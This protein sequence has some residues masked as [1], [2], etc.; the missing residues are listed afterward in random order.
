MKISFISTLDDYW[1]GSEPLWV[2]AAKVMA[3][4]GHDVQVVIYEKDKLHPLLEELRKLATSFV[5][6]KSWRV[7][8]NDSLIS[9]LYYY[10]KKK[11]NPDF[12]IKE[13]L[14]FKGDVYVLNQPGNYVGC[15][16]PDI[17][18]LLLNIKNKYILIPHGDFEHVIL[19]DEER[20]LAKVAYKNA[21][22]VCFVSQRNA[23]NV[24]HQLAMRLAPFKILDYPLNLKTKTYMNFPPIDDGFHLASVARFDA[25][26]KGQDLLFSV[27][28]QQKWK[29][30]PIR[31][32]LYGTGKDESFL[33]ELVTYYG[34]EN[35]VFFH[36]HVANV[37]NIWKENHLLV[38]PSFAEGKPL[39]LAEAMFCGRPAIVTD[40]AGN[41]ELI[42]HQ[43]NGY[44]ISSPTTNLIDEAL[45]LAW[46]ERDKWEDY[47]K[48]AH[49]FVSD[50]YDLNPIETLI[51]II[52]KCQKK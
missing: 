47:G 50:N 32:N 52:I 1:G 40:V 29:L 6:M 16:T 31:I 10:L 41:S 20:N 9:R 24:Q 26:C 17:H 8:N 4:E 22:K 3:K 46:N 25:Q 35:K 51:S 38:M 19:R 44:L 13:I 36:G 2:H 34:L 27:L 14:K 21:Q 12:N 37:Q 11:A 48:K 30:R 39:A 43:K 15:L 23:L 18:R 49:K 45:E 33:K 7:I 5:L 42:H 28:S